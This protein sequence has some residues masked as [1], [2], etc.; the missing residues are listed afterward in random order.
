MNYEKEPFPVKVTAK[1]TTGGGT[2][3]YTW[4]EQ[5]VGQPDGRYSNQV[6]ART[7]TSN[8]REVNNADVAIPF[9]AVL[10]YEGA[11]NGAPYYTFQSPAATAFV[12]PTTATSSTIVLGRQVTDG[13]LTSGST[14]LTS[15]TAAFTAADNGRPV[16]GT[17]IPAGATLTFVNA[18][19]AT[20]SAAATASGTAVTVTIQSGTT[21]G[22]S[23]YLESWSGTWSDGAV[24]WF[25]GANGETPT[26]N[27][28]YLC[29]QIGVDASGQTIWSDEISAGGGAGANCGGVPLAADFVMALSATAQNVPGMSLTLSTPGNYLLTAQISATVNVSTLQAQELEAGLIFTPNPS[30]AN[31]ASGPC[32]VKPVASTT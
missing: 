31:Q 1:T 28:R 26:A 22:Y 15:A 2:I 25:I 12:K 20:L 7:G 16:S 21:S 5:V 9:Y 8:A 6:S 3:L 13:V 14:T 32:I 17:G 10:D 30:A 23:S 4:T 19:T 29:E 11:I 27:T 18:T 24:V